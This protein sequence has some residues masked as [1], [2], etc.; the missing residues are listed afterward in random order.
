MGKIVFN[1]RAEFRE[2]LK[3]N[4][5]YSAKTAK[6]FS[7]RCTRIMNNISPDLCDAVSSEKK[8]Y[9]LMIDIRK[10]AKKC[11]TSINTTYSITGN[12]R[13]AARK[14]ALYKFPSRAKKYRSAHGQYEYYCVY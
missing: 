10:Y 14:Y 8:F 13:S 12:L 6:D 4:Y 11:S 2:W 9:Q 3:A 7:S 5:S 1:D